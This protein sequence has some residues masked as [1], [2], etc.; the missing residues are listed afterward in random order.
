MHRK[1]LVALTLFLVIS[2]VVPA[3]QAQEVSFEVS[4]N[5]ATLRTEKVVTFTIKLYN[6]NTTRLVFSTDVKNVPEGWKVDVSPMMGFVDPYTNGTI[7]VKIEVPEYLPK[8]EA[9]IT[10][11]IKYIFYG[12]EKFYE[13]REYFNIL[14]I[15]PYKILGI[16]DNPLPPPYNN[17][18]TTFLLT[19]LCWVGIGFFVIYVVGPIVLLITKKTKTQVDDILYNILKTPIIVYLVV[20]GVVSSAMILPLPTVWIEYIYLVFKIFTIIL[21]TYVAYRIFKDLLIYYGKK[22]AQKTKTNVDDVLIPIV[23]KIGDI[24]IIAAGAIGILSI[25]GINVAY[26]IAGMGVLGIVLGLAAQDTLGNLFAGIFLLADNA[27]LVGD[28][29][30]LAGDNTVYQVVKVGARSTKL[31]NLF[32]HTLE[33]VPN[34]YLAD[35]RI[36]NMV[37]PDMKYKISID[38]GVSYGSDVKKVMDILYE[39]AMEHPNVLKEEPHEPVVRFVNFGES[40]LDFKLIVWVDNM[41]NQWK[42]G[43]ELRQRILER[44]REEGIEIPFPQMDVHIKEM[45]DREEN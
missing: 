1:F 35:S 28:Y 42:V 9:N 6:L 13:H 25:F 8:G 15:R 11:I 24:V 22:Y 37:R 16:F 12:Q 2:L 36:I 20:Y 44:F 21:F 41:M 10:V 19:V 18:Y 33:I 39:V 23:E 45:V 43:S 34:R 4:G 26:F 32:E 3:S 30:M 17:E 5:K 14:V 29:I 31:Y 7:K 27:F 38:V 40:S